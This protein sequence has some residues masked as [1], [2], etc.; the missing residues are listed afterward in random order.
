[1]TYEPAE[2]M[3]AEPMRVVALSSTFDLVNV[4]A[5]VRD[6]RLVLLRP[7]EVADP[8]AIDMALAWKPQDDA[9]DR[10]PNV[11]M[12]HSIAAG[13]DSIVG[14]PSLPADAVVA[15]VRDDAQAMMMAGF[16]AAHVVWH[17]RRMADHTRAQAEGLW[18]RSFRPPMSSDVT[19]GILGFGL[20]GRACARAIAALGYRVIAA[21]NSA[22]GTAEGVEI[23]SGPSAIN[24]VAARADILVNVLPLTDATRDI[25]NADLFA[26]MP[27][28]A[29]LVQIG[30]GE[31]L[32]DADLLAALDAGRI[33]SATLDVFR[34][35]PLP[36]G[37]PY[38]TRKEV[39]MTPHKASDSSHGEIMR[40]LVENCELYRAG[41]PPKG[42]VDR[43]NGY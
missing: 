4:F 39:L 42:R 27:M 26:R 10:F 1:M 12:V 32:V 21:R 5:K 24:E 15:R 28:G 37:H 34:Q 14:C 8:M 13:V 22:G 38:W 35:E 11:R 16:A 30:R 43:G 36:A 20:M 40:Q 9:F 2:P 23:L 41:Q 6:P 7:E 33:R 25:L 3:R 18:E 17:H 19:V 29:S 31:Q